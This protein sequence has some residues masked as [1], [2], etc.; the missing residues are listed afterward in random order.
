M[1]LGTLNQ[2]ID[3]KPAASDFAIIDAPVPTCPEDGV[4]VR[5]VHLS[6]DPYVGSRLR[7][8][9]MGEAPPEPMKG[10]IPGAIVGQVVESR[11]A[12]CLVCQA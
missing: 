7:G 12:A 11:A 6:L 4:L 1:Q 3:H 8:R 9:H 10:A 2:A 5:V